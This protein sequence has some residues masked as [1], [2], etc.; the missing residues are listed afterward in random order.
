[1]QLMALFDVLSSLCHMSG[2]EYMSR[3]LIDEGDPLFTFIDS[4]HVK[5]LLFKVIEDSSYCR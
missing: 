1:M 5:S 3:E 4:C 2:R